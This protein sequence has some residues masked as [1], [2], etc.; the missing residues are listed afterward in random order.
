[1][2][3]RVALQ[4]LVLRVGQHL[5]AVPTDRVRELMHMAAVASSPGQPSLLEG[6]L[7]LRGVAVPVIRLRELFRQEH[8]D[9]QMYTP[10]IVLSMDGLTLALEADSVEEVVEVDEASVRPLGEGHSANECGASV[11]TWNEDDV[12]LLSCDLLL[13][14]KEKE[15]LQELQ[16]AM[17]QRIGE[18]GSL[19]G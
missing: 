5:Y 19:A 3:R 8:R 9:P 18:L 17:Q 14:A 1:M 15:C 10:L 7:N 12:V 2:G 4:V 16:A 11:F 13:L 6:F